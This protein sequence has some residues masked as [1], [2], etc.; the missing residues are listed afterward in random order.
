MRTIGSIPGFYLVYGWDWYFWREAH[1]YFMSPF[2][3]FLWVTSLI[4][5]CVY[6]YALWRIKKKT[7]EVLGDG[8]KSPRNKMNRHDE[9]K[10]Q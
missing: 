2:A 9:R 7:E 10:L 5:D 1:E 6:P 3:L 4:C 8:R